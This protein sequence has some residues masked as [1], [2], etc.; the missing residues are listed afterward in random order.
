MNMHWHKRHEMKNRLAERVRG[1]VRVTID[2]KQLQAIFT[3]LRTEGVVSSRRDFARKCG[4]SSTTV[5]DW[6]NE[7]DRIDSKMSTLEQVSK[8]VLPHLQRAWDMDEDE[9]AEALLGEDSP[10]RNDLKKALRE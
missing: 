9:L 7:P 6:L 5:D 10:M 2:P 3:L 4:I 8:F 1:A